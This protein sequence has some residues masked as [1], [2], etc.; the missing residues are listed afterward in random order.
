MKKALFLTLSA[1]ALA[2]VSCQNEEVNSAT[3]KTEANAI[4]FAAM[5]S[6]TSHSRATITNSDNLTSTKFYVYAFNSETDSV[7]MGNPNVGTFE[8]QKGVEQEYRDGMWNYV[9]EDDLAYW[10]SDGSKLDFWAINPS[11]PRGALQLSSDIHGKKKGNYYT[12]AL[13]N[14]YDGGSKNYDVMYA[15]ALNYTKSVRSDQKVKLTFH[16]IFSQLVFKARTANASLSVDVNKVTLYNPHYSGRVTFPTELKEGDEHYCRDLQ[17]S[18]YTLWLVSHK[19]GFTAS[20]ASDVVS[21]TEEAVWLSKESEPLIVAPQ[22]LSPWTTT[23]TTAVPISTADE[24]KNTYL[25]ISMRLQ[26]NGTY[27]IGS[28]SEYTT[29]YMPFSNGTEGWLPGK[30]YIY[31]LVF[32]GGYNSD[33]KLILDP[34]TFE[35]V[36]DDWTDE[37]AE[38]TLP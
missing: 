24:N 16:H 29:V 8:E 7:F 30:R 32:G 34:I 21:A 5:G 20:L 25:A 4:S 33:G 1:S 19:Q 9:V 14:E 31:T 28:S 13:D 23:S 15:S 37:D 2:L 10:P 11:T 3:G 27:V 17:L 22:V 18:D 36:V 12:F 26:K 35:P 6:N 38:T